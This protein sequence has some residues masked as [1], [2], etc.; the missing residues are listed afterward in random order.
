MTPAERRAS[1][2]K[3]SKAAALA[4]GKRSL[5]AEIQA[6]EPDTS[7]VILSSDQPRGGLA[8]VRESLAVEQQTTGAEPETLAESTPTALI[9][10]D[11]ETIEG[12]PSNEPL[13]QFQALEDAELLEVV[14]A[15]RNGEVPTL[16]ARAVLRKI[17]DTDLTRQFLEWLPR[18][19]Q[20]SRDPA[21]FQ[22][23]FD[24]FIVYKAQTSGARVLLSDRVLTRVIQWTLSGRTKS[25]SLGPTESG[26]SYLKKFTR[27]V[28][29]SAEV[30]R[31]KGRGDVPSQHW[32]FK[33]EIKKELRALQ[34]EI[35]S[36][37]A[38]QR[39]S[40]PAWVQIEETVT[41]SPQAYP[42]LYK[43]LRSL[44]AFCN[45]H[46]LECK[47]FVAGTTKPACFFDLWGGWTTNRDPES[48]R[49]MVSMSRRK[50]RRE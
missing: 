14:A 15:V 33:M 3:A 8:T 18:N 41:R 34:E 20:D 47:N 30:R 16:S 49:R 17:I 6:H 5:T 19:L 22:K 32:T 45:G 10:L 13:P 37:G 44:A 27:A 31:G 2:R 48:Y 12:L 42:R 21:A 1:A 9:P 39:S 24:D 29:H 23:P 38:R 35:R 26:I 28:V 25:G 11:W 40:P 7:E 43:N 46:T 50:F 4:S 36:A